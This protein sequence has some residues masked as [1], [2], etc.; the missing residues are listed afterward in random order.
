MQR[1][2][3]SGTFDFLREVALLAIINRTPDS[4]LDL[5]LAIVANQPSR[6][7]PSF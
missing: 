2:S 5:T 4:L 1:R 6:K 3:G 7:K